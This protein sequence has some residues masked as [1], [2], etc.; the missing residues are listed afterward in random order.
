MKKIAITFAGRENRMGLQLDFMKT[1]LQNKIVDEWHVWNFSR[2]KSDNEWLWQELGDNY[3]LLTSPTDN[4]YRK[5]PLQPGK[6]QKIWVTAREKAALLIQFQ[7]GVIFEILFGCNNNKNSSARYF[8]SI[9]DFDNSTPFQATVQKSLNW[10]VRNAIELIVINNKL[11][12]QLNDDILFSFNIKTSNDEIQ[13]ISA[14]TKDGSEGVWDLNENGNIKLIHA[15]ENGYSGFKRTYIHYSNAN[16]SNCTFVKMDDDII[17][18][19]ISELNKLINYTRSN[20]DNN[21]YSANVIN[22]GVCA[23]YQKNNGLLPNLNIDFEY[24]KDGLFGSLWGSAKKCGLLHEYFIENK[25]NIILNAKKEPLETQLPYYDRFSINFICF[26]HGLLKYMAAVYSICPQENDD[27]Y[28]MTCLLPK[29]F[30]IKKYI[31]NHLIV[32]HLSFYKQEEELDFSK[33]ISTYSQ[34]KISS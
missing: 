22:N 3:S 20:G 34:R 13:F 10:D 7:S 9:E 33:I 4:S 18:C 30:G 27:E 21:I 1:A 24:P 2:N 29:I 32:S 11:I 6:Y 28:I 25:T 14:S 17:Y 26:N 15:M 12:I 23:F 5:L 16:Y 8:S 31:Y 19:D